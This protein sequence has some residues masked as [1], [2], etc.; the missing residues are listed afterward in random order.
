MGRR[1]E[2]RVAEE[3]GWSGEI[4]PIMDGYRLGCCDCGLVHEVEFR[5]VRKGRNLPDGSW[6]YKSLNK[7]GYRVVFRVRR[8]EKAT[9]AVRREDKKRAAKKRGR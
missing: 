6:R 3:D 9:A 7:R 8:D 2:N 5:A 4:T 1:Y